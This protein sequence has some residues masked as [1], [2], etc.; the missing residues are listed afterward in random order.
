MDSSHRRLRQRIYGLENAVLLGSLLFPK[1]VLIH[2]LPAFLQESVS[3]R[4]LPA[5]LA[6]ARQY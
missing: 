3:S 5:F 1:V 6:L 2:V 4:L